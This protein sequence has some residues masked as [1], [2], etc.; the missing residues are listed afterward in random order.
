[1]KK[2]PYPGGRKFEPHALSHRA[3]YFH[4]MVE[5]DL[6]EK[7][8]ASATA[9]RMTASEYIRKVMAHATDIEE[10]IGLMTPR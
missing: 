8:V 3:K 10:S 1:M 6:F 9:N 7:V 5:P 2:R 4:V